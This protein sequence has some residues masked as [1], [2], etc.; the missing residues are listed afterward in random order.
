MGGPSGKLEIAEK[1]GRF[2]DEGWRVRKDGS[3]FWASVAITALRGPDQE[4]RG[5]SKV[6]RDLSERKALEERTQEL[7]K[8]LRTRMAQSSSESRSQ[9]ELRTIEQF[10]E[11]D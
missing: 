2:M 5:F 3:L 4:L 11:L 6:T 1:Q 8:E 7:N 9:L 10:E